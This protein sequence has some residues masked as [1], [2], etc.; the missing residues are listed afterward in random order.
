MDDSQFN[1]ERATNGL[2]LAL[3]LAAAVF[4]A[5]ML[6]Y[7]LRDIDERQSASTD[8]AA[9]LQHKVLWNGETVASEAHALPCYI[10]PSA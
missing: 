4:L 10:P 3:Y 8:D 6:Y 2:V 5:V 9:M 7:V 1:I